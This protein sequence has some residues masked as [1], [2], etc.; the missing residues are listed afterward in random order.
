VSTLEAACAELNDSQ[1]TAMDVEGHCV[2]I[3]PPG[4][5][6]TKLLVTRL[7][8]DLSD[9]IDPPSGAACVTLTT[10]AAAELS[11]RFGLLSGDQRSNLFIGTVHGFALNR[12]LRPYAA[13]AGLPE[14]QDA[15]VLRRR[16]AE[17][18]WAETLRQ[19]EIPDDPLLLNTVRKLRSEFASEHQWSLTGSAVQARDAYLQ[20]LRDNRLLD[21]ASII[22]QAVAIVES[23]V[24]V[25]LALRAAFERIYVDEYQDLAPGLDRIVRELC[26]SAEA[27]PSTLFAVGDT[28]QAIYGWTGTDSR[29]LTDLASQPGVTEIALKT[30]YRC[31]AVIAEIS[32][33]LFPD[34]RPMIAARSGGSIDVVKVEGSIKGQ[35]TRIAEEVA[36]LVE[37]NVSPDAI[38]LLCRTNELARAAAKSLG[39]RGI[40]TWVREDAEWESMTT[41]WLERACGTLLGLAR[42][43][44]IGAL[45]DE[46]ARIVP[47][48]DVDIRGQI[49][50]LLLSIES[51]MSAR[52]L[53]SDLLNLLVSA[54]ADAATVATD[55]LAPLL[56][57]FASDPHV[58]RSVDE[59]AARQL[60]DGRVYVTT[61]S[62]GKGLEFD[63]VFI[64]DCDDGRIPFYRSVNNRRELGEERNKFYVGLTRARLKVTL[65]WSGY[66]TDRWDRRHPCPVSRFVTQLRLA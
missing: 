34:G 49:V 25:R 15:R 8:R 59:L 24:D 29:L 43:A 37:S 54:D 16:E 22:E 19:E 40:D 57:H 56:G 9:R 14:L 26:L 39:D 23:H 6:K 36:L 65:L 33:R 3:A 4:S 11:S 50:G 58:L 5:G 45:V 13:L 53:T 55:E 32:R 62:A 48:L 61:L 47:G 28:D 44:G 35:V 51:G 31:G 30:S 20:L 41:N 52:Q 1:I 10:A 17:A 12:I 64:P 38:G 66:T 42:G 7:A 27:D 63:Y 2:V 21:F 60:R 18:L 46:L